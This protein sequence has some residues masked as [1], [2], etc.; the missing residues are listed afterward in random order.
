MHPIIVHFV[1]AMVFFSCSCDALV[2]R[3]V[4]LAG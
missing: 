4:N 3:Q 1:I 2:V